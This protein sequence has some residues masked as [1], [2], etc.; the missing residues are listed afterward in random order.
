MKEVTVIPFTSAI[1]ALVVALGLSPQEDVAR[2]HVD[3]MEVNHFYDE[4]GR[5]VI[6]QVHLLRLVR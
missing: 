4:Q 2:E 6:D 3:L 5:L 1:G